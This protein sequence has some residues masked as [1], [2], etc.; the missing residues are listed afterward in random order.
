MTTNII[1][2]NEGGDLI[3]KI[4]EDECIGYVRNKKN[5]YEKRR[6]LK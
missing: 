4:A 2:Y 6:I 1:K 5:I 3:I